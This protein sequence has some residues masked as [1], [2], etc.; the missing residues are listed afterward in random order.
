VI[1]RASSRIREKADEAEKHGNAIASAFYNASASILDFSRQLWEAGDQAKQWLST[2]VPVIGGAL[3]EIAQGFLH[4]VSLLVSAN[5]MVSN[6]LGDV[7]TRLSGLAGWL[8]DNVS[9]FIAN[10]GNALN[11]F[12]SWARNQLQNAWNGFT[13]TLKSTL[14]TVINAV[15]GAWDKITGFFK[16]IADKLGLGGVVQSLSN[17]VSNA[18]KGVADALSSFGKALTGRNPGVI[19]HLEELG[20]SLRNVSDAVAGLSI[21]PAGGD[22]YSPKIVDLL[23]ELIEEVRMLREEASRARPEVNVNIKASEGL[24]LRRR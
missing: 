18:F 20:S 23:A 13:N 12:V 15:S 5:A 17:M 8:R 24:Y 2:H 6:F 3:G 7:S 11:G 16:G 1:E 10:M 22:Q 14:D 4:G 21:R 9:S 19:T